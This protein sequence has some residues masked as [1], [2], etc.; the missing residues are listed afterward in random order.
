MYIKLHIVYWLSS[1]VQ[2]PQSYKA[3]YFSFGIVKEILLK[4]KQIFV[5]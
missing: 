3:K 4:N 1:E 2:V 5:G